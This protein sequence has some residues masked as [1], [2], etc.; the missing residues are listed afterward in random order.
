MM[1]QLF[2]ERA[3]AYY[4][5]IVT[6]AAPVAVFYGVIEDQAAPLW[7]GLA[8]SVFGTGMARVN[9]STRQPQ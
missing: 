9:T 8:A 3:R 5:G 7:I 1:D 6:A 2:S 4:Y